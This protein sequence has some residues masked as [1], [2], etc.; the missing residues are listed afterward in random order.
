MGTGD[1]F[2]GIKGQI[3]ALN[4]RRASGGFGNII[5]TRYIIKIIL[6]ARK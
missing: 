1:F 3:P 4:D 5:Q 6:V 2:L